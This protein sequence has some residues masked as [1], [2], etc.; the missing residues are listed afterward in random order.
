MRSR[1]KEKPMPELPEVEDGAPHLGAFNPRKDHRKGS[2]DPPEKLRDQPQR[3]LPMILLAKT[4]LGISRIGKYLA[5]HLS[6]DFGD[7]VSPPNGRKVLLKIREGPA[8]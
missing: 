6:G 5:F 4:F 2:V 1:K 8:R 3:F 7:R